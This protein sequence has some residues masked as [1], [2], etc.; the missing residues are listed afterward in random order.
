MTARRTLYRLALGGVLVLLALG[1]AIGLGACTSTIRP[2]R[3]VP[4]E[5]AETVWVVQDRM[6]LGLWFR[7]DAGGLVEYGYGEWDWYALGHKGWPRVFPVILWPT[8]GTLARRE[9]ATGDIDEVRRHFPTSHFEPLVADLDKVRALRA[10]LDATFE[11]AARRA[12]VG[13]GD[14]N[15][16]FVPSDDDYWCLWNCNDAAADWLRALGCDVSSWP[17]RTGIRF[18]P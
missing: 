8:A 10:R 2:P 5:R 9:V 11:A 1:V 17:L 18:A 12:V 15:M 3:D 16:A 14:W 7:R 13:G 6:H 4:P